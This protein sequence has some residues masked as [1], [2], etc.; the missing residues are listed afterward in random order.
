MW[1]NL[2][3]EFLFG[4]PLVR[5]VLPCIHL[6]NTA[7]GICMRDQAI[8]SVFNLKLRARSRVL[9]SDTVLVRNVTF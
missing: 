5:R 9:G 7:R 6:Q 2:Y 3:G 1:C 8:R 4:D